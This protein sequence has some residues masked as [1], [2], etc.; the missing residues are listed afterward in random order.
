MK[1]GVDLRMYRS[2][3]A[4]IG[5]YSQNLIE[6][7]LKLDKTNRYIFFMTSDDIKEINPKSEIRNPKHKVVE[8]NIPH[9]SIAEQTKLPKIIE[10]ENVDLMFFTN[11][12]YPVRYRG[13]F[14][15]AIHDLTLYFFP[16]TARKNNFLRRKA[17]NFVLKNAVQKS[18]KIITDSENTKKDILKVYHPDPGKIKVIMLAADDKKLAEP[19][20]EII[21]KLK[22][23]FNIEGPVILYVGQ[24]RAHKNIA[25]LVRAFDIV[26]KNL[27]AKLILV[28]KPDP[29]YTEL[30]ET[31][32]KSPYKSDI[33]EPG[34]VS[35]EDLSAWYKLSKCYAFPSLYEGFGLPALEAMT[36]GTAVVTSDRSSLPEVCG[37][38]A[39]YFDPE[40]AD[41]MADKIIMVLTDENLRNKLIEKGKIQ[42][43][44]FSWKV[45]AEET[46]KIFK[47]V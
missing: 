11:T 24:F 32:D 41:V 27:S 43:A 31:I 17:F 46:L 12:N 28:G 7:L 4:G 39:V 20:P 23:K 5:R 45:T 30:V 9:Y 16:E 42:A 25:N 6:N 47:S 14:I 34:F 21:E 8:V 18:A 40:N 38:A 33:I 37:E 19:S 2:S 35:D 10:K 36:A 1:I 26:R 13:K 15:V 29:N 22:S 44:K 3:V